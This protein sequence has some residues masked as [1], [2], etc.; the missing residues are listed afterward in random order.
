MVTYYP[1]NADFTVENPDVVSA[2]FDR[3]A[4]VYAGRPIVITEAGYP[5]S[6]DCR[7]SDAMQAQFV[8]NVF[9]A[10]DAN[11]TQIV[12]ITFSWLT[13]IS[14]DAVSGYAKY[15]A[16]GSRPFAEFL[17][18]LGLRTYPGPGQDKPGFTALAAEAHKR[19]W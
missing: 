19:G 5:T 17:R 13:D 4:Q 7:S 3:L 16:V 9:R 11:S 8:D 6:S 12:S 15:Y 18:T 1:L 2:D 14:P 10:W